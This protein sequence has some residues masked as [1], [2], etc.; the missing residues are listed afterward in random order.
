MLWLFQHLLLLRE[1]LSGWSFEKTH[2]QPVGAG[3]PT[4]SALQ[5]S[6]L[7]EA[8]LWSTSPS[9]AL[10]LCICYVFLSPNYLQIILCSPDYSQASSRGSVKH[11][12]VRLYSL[13]ALCGVFFAWLGCC[14]VSLFYKQQNKMPLSPPWPEEKSNPCSLCPLSLIH[15]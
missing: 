3:Y 5:G 1:Q 6:H 13:V 2:R 14:A 4:P 7:G 15:I 11:Y 12:L 8:V 10:G 9:A